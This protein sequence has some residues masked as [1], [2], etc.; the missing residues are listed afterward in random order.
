MVHVV[1]TMRMMSSG[2]AAISVKSG[3]MESAS[4]SHLQRLSI[5][6]NTSAQAAAAIKGLDHDQ[7]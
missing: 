5:S 1:T 4:G 6:S 3:S 2:Y 7:T